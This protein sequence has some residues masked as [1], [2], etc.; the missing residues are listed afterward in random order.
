MINIHE[1]SRNYRWWHTV[2]KKKCF[3]SHFFTVLPAL[4]LSLITDVF[5]NDIFHM[6]LPCKLLLCFIQLL[7]HDERMKPGPEYCPRASFAIFPLFSGELSSHLLLLKR[8]NALGKP[9][10]NCRRFDLQCHHK[11]VTVFLLCSEVW[12]LVFRDKAWFSQ[13]CQPMWLFVSWPPLRY[14]SHSRLPLNS[15]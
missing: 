11:Q 8:S 4:I 5:Y 6:P 10:K 7:S 9:P 2:T 15:R 3:C 1:L 13:R 12:R 14:G